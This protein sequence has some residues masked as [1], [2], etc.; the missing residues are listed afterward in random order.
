MPDQLSGGET[1]RAG[2][3]VALAAGPM[4]VVADEPTGELD[5]A[6]EADVLALLRERTTSGGAVLVVTHSATVM[7]EAD[8]TVRLV[9]GKV[10]A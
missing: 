1:A 2:L 3:A 4:L 8:R 10:T 7:T 9:D 6:A 5:S